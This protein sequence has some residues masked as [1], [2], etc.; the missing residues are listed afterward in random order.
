M[1]HHGMFFRFSKIRAMTS[2]YQ[3]DIVASCSWKFYSKVL[4]LI[5]VLGN[6]IV[7]LGMTRMTALVMSMLVICRSMAQ[8]GLIFDRQGWINQ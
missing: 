6:R 2:I 1:P 7:F 5:M 4:R 8:A 3:K